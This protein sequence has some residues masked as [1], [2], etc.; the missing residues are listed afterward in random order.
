MTGPKINVYCK[1]DKQ[2]LAVAGWELRRKGMQLRNFITEL[3]GLTNA[4]Y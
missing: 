3:D 1:H 4:V 2:N